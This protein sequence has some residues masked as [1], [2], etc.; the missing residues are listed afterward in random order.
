[1]VRGGTAG[2]M[3]ARTGRR[4][5]SCGCGAAWRSC[6]GTSSPPRRSGRWPRCWPDTGR[7]T[8]LRAVRQGEADRGLKPG[9]AR[10]ATAGTRGASSRRRPSQRGR[11]AGRHCSAATPPGGAGVGL[12]PAVPSVAPSGRGRG[13]ARPAGSTTPR[14]AGLLRTRLAFPERDQAALRTYPH[15]EPHRR[16]IV[17]HQPWRQRGSGR[18]T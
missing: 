4:S 8:S 7:S 6:G 15:E 18:T 1:M 17:P 10:T 13:P 14:R 3:S 11:S 5:T 12:R 9:H 16:G 2:G